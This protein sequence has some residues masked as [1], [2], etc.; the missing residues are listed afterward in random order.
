[1]C[2]DALSHLLTRVFQCDIDRPKIS[3]PRH[4]TLEPQIFKNFD[5]LKSIKAKVEILTYFLCHFFKVTRMKH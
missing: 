5:D 2:V 1:M 4:G 3:S